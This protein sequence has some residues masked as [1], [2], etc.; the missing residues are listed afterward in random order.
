MYKTL[1]IPDGIFMWYTCP[2]LQ[3]AEDNIDCIIKENCHF[4]WIKNNKNPIRSEFE[5]IYV[6]TTNQ[7]DTGEE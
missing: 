6:D 1:Y 4:N 3:E 5:V 7:N 2:T